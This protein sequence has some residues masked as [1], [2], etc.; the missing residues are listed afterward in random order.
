MVGQQESKSLAN[1]LLVYGYDPYNSPLYPN[2]FHKEVVKKIK[3]KN[4]LNVRILEYKGK[5]VD[6]DPDGELHFSFNRF[7]EKFKP[8]DYAINLRDND[9]MWS[10]LKGNPYFEFLY[11]SRIYPDKKLVSEFEWYS[12]KLQK[13][14][15][16]RWIFWIINPFVFEREDYP[17]DWTYLSV[18]LFPEHVTKTEALGQVLGLI[19]LLQKYPLPKPEQQA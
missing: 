10:G 14:G 7:A 1:I 11:E 3:E 4:L 8:F 17:N 2:N 16:G 13:K 5:V 6:Y 19:S 15:K 9:G 12:R 18:K